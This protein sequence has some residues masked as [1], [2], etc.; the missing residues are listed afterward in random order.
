M[1]A[2][3]IVEALKTR[4]GQHARVYWTRTLKT[5]KDVPC[6]VTKHTTA[7]VRAG[8]NYAN[9]ASVREGIEAGEREEV[10]PLKWGTW[11]QFPFII[12]HKGNDYVRLYPAVFENLKTPEVA[13]FIDGK[14]ATA[15]ECKAL[16]LASEFRER[17]DELTCF[18]INTAN[19][20]GIED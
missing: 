15:E 2:T 10:Q 11:S 19:I 3:Q 4:K 9:L 13:Y 17:E 20:Q 7:W 5:L 16:C 1:N 14:E 6:V 12:T 18:T 8:I